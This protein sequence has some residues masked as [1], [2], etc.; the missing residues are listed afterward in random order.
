MSHSPWGTAGTR[1]CGHLP[2]IKGERQLCRRLQ[3]LE[4]AQSLLSSLLL[5][6][7]SVRDITGC[8]GH[9]VRITLSMNTMAKAWKGLVWCC[10]CVFECYILTLKIW[11]T[12]QQADPHYTSFCC[13][14]LA[15]KLSLRGWVEGS[16]AW[17]LR[18]GPG[19]GKEEGV[20]M[21]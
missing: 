21:K 4:K 18:Q 5:S 7:E 15:P 20:T 9:V 2:R 19:G 8:S 1:M 11:L 14:N 17:G 13:V 12:P 6:S 16:W 10:C 3:G